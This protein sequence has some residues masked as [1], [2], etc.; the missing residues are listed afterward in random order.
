MPKE[1]T[2]VGASVSATES[3]TI[4]VHA[5]DGGNHLVGIGNLRVLIVPDGEFW[6]AQGL[7]IDYGAQGDTKEE[8]KIN[9]QAGLYATIALQLTT[10][11]NIDE[12]LKFAPDE[13]LQEASRKKQSIHQ[14]AHVSTHE[15]PE[16][17]LSMFP[18]DGIDYLAVAA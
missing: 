11:G 14:F 5:K 6:Y 16:L 2:S 15:V 4:A 13:I 10:N 1:R 17:A 18:F 7:E 9:F 3:G 8:A 12:I